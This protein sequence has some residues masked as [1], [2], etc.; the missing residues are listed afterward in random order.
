MTQTR[1]ARTAH[2]E[3]VLEDHLVEQL[4]TCQGYR[5]REPDHYDRTSA[6]DKTLVLEFVQGTQ[7]D[8]W[9][10]LVTHYAGSAEDEFFKQLD[11]ALK[12]RGTLDV[13]RNGL[14]LIP[15]LKFALCVFKPASGLNAELTRLFAAN[16]LSVIRQVRYSLKNENAI[17]IVLFVNG[18][19]VATLELKNLLTGSTFRHAEKQYK[20]DRSPANEPLLTFKRGALVH[21][22]LDEDNVSMA[23]RLLNGKTV[24]LPF[25]RGHEGGSG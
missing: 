15:G 24:F 5:Q 11:R 18:L 21:F 23:T 1:A 7:A 19:P 13:L 4:I 10:K 2:R 8:E 20:Y 14:K 3:I 16:V 17:D 22:A 6:L 12:Q 9:A 25:N